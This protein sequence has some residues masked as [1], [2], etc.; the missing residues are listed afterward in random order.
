MPDGSDRW[1]LE[2]IEAARGLLDQEGTEVWETSVLPGTG[3]GVGAS[4]VVRF[5]STTRAAI[6]KLI[7][8]NDVAPD[9]PLWWQREREVYESTWL[10]E[11]MPVGLDLPECLGSTT[12]RDAAVIILA[13]VPFDDHTRRSVGWYRSLATELGRLN[14][15]SITHPPP[16]ATQGF[17][18]A[19]AATA[20][21]LI[22][23]ALAHPSR[24][25]SDLLRT[26][27]PLLERIA[28]AGAELI[29]LLDSLPSG[30]HHLDAFSRNAA[31]VDERFVLIDWAYAG[32][33]PIGSDAAALISITAMHCDV[34]DDRLEDFHEVAVSGY[35]EGLAAV[36]VDLTDADL[37]QAIDVQLTLRFARF[38]TQ[39]HAAGEEIV[40]AEALVERSF[41]E[42]MSWWIEMAHHLRPG[43]ERSLAI[44]GQ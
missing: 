2:G 1:I 17:T 34:P 27:Q 29:G 19:E 35:H 40:E 23:D 13:E 7:R 24:S 31:L 4:T 26:W 11:R 44:V 22:P 32:V 25:S 12:T 6:A 16:W 3:G 5:D 28:A 36:G 38:L 41:G 10:R 39:V 8:R 43:A 37:R 33:A 20:A 14:G 9:H 18:A 42:M 30:L 15:P 21:E